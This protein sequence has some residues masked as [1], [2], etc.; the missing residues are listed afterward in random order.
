MNYRCEGTAAWSLIDTKEKHRC[1]WSRDNMSQRAQ[2]VN[3]VTSEYCVRNSLFQ[4][5]SSYNFSD[6]PFMAVCINL[7]LH[8]L[9]IN[10]F[11]VQ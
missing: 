6:L 9:L 4:K 3:L 1:D 7:N 8:Y 5:G 2:T 10:F 11:I